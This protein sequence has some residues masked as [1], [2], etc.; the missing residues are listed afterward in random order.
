MKGKV[1]QDASSLALFS[2]DQHNKGS[3][4]ARTQGQDGEIASVNASGVV[5]IS[6]GRDQ[7]LLTSPEL[8]IRLGRKFIDD[9]ELLPLLLSHGLIRR[10]RTIQIEV[11]PLGGDSFKITLDSSKA[12]VGEAKAEITRSQGTAE[13]CQ[14]LYKVAE[15]ADGL[16][17][18]ED[19]AEPELLDDESMLLGDGETVAMAVKESPLLWRTFAADRIT[20]SEGGA[21]AT[22]TAQLE[23]SLTTTGIE[24]TE[25]KEVELL[26]EE[27]R[28]TYFGISRPNL[29]PKGC[30][31]T[32]G[33][34]DGW[35]IG[36]NFAA[37]Y[38][39]GKMGSNDAVPDNQGDRVGVLLDLDNGS[40]R[41]FKNGVQHGPGY[42]AGSVNGPVVHA[43]QL[44][45]TN[46]SVRLLPDA[47]VPTALHSALYCIQRRYDTFWVA[48]RWA[49]FSERIMRKVHPAESTVCLSATHYSKQTYGSVAD[50]VHACAR[51]QSTNC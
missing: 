50:C 41:F 51:Q 30:Y 39:N 48:R 36:A 35:F 15:R 27:M 43:V 13:E 22:Q 19:D 33:C 6:Q 26:S 2:S 44:Y 28:S 38:G 49:H 23:Y 46:A 17:V 47:Q 34:T 24:L 11:R 29:D 3:K 20:L 31:L 32:S 42:P 25:G 5:D 45:N 9:T 18:R 16:A 7:L 14:D 1:V 12:T 40:L 8:Q 10:V 4:R 37:L 21:V